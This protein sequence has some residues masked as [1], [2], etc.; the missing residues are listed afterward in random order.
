MNC[1]S[2]SA[3]AWG[4]DS[5]AHRAALKAGGRTIAVQGCGLGHIFPPENA[6]LYRA[7]TA[8]GAVIS[9]LPML[10][11]PLSKNFPKRNT[12]G[13]SCMICKATL[14]SI[15]MYPMKK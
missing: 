1:G 6:D 4:I 9:E 10:G 5:A 13:K 11:E 2:G 14:R 8:Q 12:V 3:L 7:I 15:G